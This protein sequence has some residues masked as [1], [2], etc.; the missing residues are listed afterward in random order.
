MSELIEPH[1]VL[2]YKSLKLSRHL[3]FIY[4][5]F[6]KSKSLITIKVS[7]FRLKK[8]KPLQFFKFIRVTKS[9][10][11]VCDLDYT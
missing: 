10:L 9:A 3:F 8:L 4:Y 6:A 1:F 5:F 2:V 7:K 11:E